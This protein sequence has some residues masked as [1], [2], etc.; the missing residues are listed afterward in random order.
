MNLLILQGPNLNL[1]GLKSSESKNNLTLDKLN[2]AIKKHIHRKDVEVKILQT[3]KT[4]QAVNFIQRNRNW[5]DGL[6]IIP[7]SWAK[8]EW[9][10]V[11]TIALTQIKTI[12]VKFEHPFSFSNSEDASIF[13]SVTE[14]TIIDSPKDACNR[15]VDFFIK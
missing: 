1:L 11:E 9:T 2:R 4:F 14:S 7:T 8:Y 15:A 13:D 5:A 10:I 6:I 3:H 12:Q